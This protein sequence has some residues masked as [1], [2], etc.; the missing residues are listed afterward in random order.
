MTFATEAFTEP[1]AIAGPTTAT[2]FA[3]STAPDTEF[4]VQLIDEGP[5]GSRSYLQ[6]GMLKA[7]H[8]A[9]DRRLSD[10]TESGLIYRP[11]RHHTNPT[12]VTP[13]STYK[14]LIEVFPVAHIFRP[15]HR[16]LVKIHAPPAVDSYYAYVPKRAPSVNTVFHDEA[17]PSHL[18]LPFVPLKGVQ[19]GAEPAPCTVTAVRC[20]PGG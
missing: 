4:F 9:I 16:L 1:T 14:Y 10:K 19:L 7:S 20:I 11:Y 6:R 17:N 2:L 12:L 18:T 8:R 13:G 3:S 15:G 5:D